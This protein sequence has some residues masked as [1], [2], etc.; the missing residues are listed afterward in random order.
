M[1]FNDFKATIIARAAE[2]GVADYELY[3]QAAESTSISAFQ[4]GI[5]QFSSSTEGGVCLRCIVDGKMGYA[6]TEALT[7]AEAA[8]LLDRAMENARSLEATEP[9][10]L[11]EGGKT[12]AKVERKPMELPTTEALVAKVLAVQEELYAADPA[13]IDGSMTR[14]I[15]EKSQ[16]AIYN[17]RGLD[18]SSESTVA[19]LMVAAVVTDGKEM[20]NDY[21]L[22]LGSLD[23][24]DTAA[25]TKKAAEEAKRKLGGDVAPTGQYPV[26]FSPDAM[27]SLLSTFSGI[28]SGEAAQKGLSKLQGKEGQTIAAENVTLVDDPF[29][30]ENLM[31]SPFDA[32][33]TP[34]R[35]KALIEKGVFRT[36]LHNLKTAN[37]AGVPSTGNASKAGYDAP[38]GIRPFT[39]YLEGGEMSEEALLQKAGD[40]VYITSLGGLHAGANPITGDFS[41]QSAGFLV[42]NGQKTKAVKS[43]TVAGNFYQLLQNVTALA[44]NS[45]IPSPMGSTAFGAPTT[46]ISGLSV[47]GK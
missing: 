12:Y 8:T 17:S 35:K 47:A 6:S 41:L 19:G 44:N 31:P 43:F 42:E 16:L 34:T 32:E 2:L 33:G 22:K 10:F 27:C 45:H 29:H 1:N 26:I 4:H 11:G 3:Y 25:L 40:G 20:A 13:V 30:P 21:Q 28:F 24:L 39:L 5:D 46:W 37:M 7:E 14:G 15:C 9:V 23:T 18:L 36:L 38:V